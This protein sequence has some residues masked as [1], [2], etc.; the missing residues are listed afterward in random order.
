MELVRE[1]VAEGVAHPFELRDALIAG[2][3]DKADV[4]EG[5]EDEVGVGNK[6][7]GER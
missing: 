5:E 2:V 4:L 7:G 6:E 3:F 1:D